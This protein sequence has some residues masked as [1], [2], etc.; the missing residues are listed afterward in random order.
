MAVCIAAG[1]RSGLACFPAGGCFGLGA[2]VE[3]HHAPTFSWLTSCA[4]AIVHFAK[5]R[6]GELVERRS[7]GTHPHDNWFDGLQWDGQ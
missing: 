1:K 7:D 4:A 2:A 6:K 5:T 3:A